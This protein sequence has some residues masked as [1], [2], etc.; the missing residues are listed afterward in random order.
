MS[1]SWTGREDKVGL[2]KALLPITH[3]RLALGP[4]G[5]E[6]RLWLLPLR[7]SAPT[8]HPQEPQNPPSPKTRGAGLL[9]SEGTGM[10]GHGNGGKRERD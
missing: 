9:C 8:Q 5:E 2:I 3:K 4:V 6:G 1:N 10:W 7:P